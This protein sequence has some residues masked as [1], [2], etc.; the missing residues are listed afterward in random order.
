MYIFM[1]VYIFFLQ[2]ALNLHFDVISP[3]Q[4]LGEISQAALNQDR[5]G[6]M[7]FRQ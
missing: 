6:L 1:C 7:D 4:M 2:T 5:P 3:D